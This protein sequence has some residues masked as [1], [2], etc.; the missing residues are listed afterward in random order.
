MASR[1]TLFDSFLQ[2]SNSMFLKAKSVMSLKNSSLKWLCCLFLFFS[3][4][5]SAEDEIYDAFRLIDGAQ[6]AEEMAFWISTSGYDYSDVFRNR[7]RSSN[8]IYLQFGEAFTYPQYRQDIYALED[9]V[10]RQEDNSVFPF[11]LYKEAIKLKQGN[12]RLGFFLV[13]NFL[14]RDW[15]NESMRNSFSR[16]KKLYDITG[17][18]SRFIS[19]L[20]PVVE[21]NS[22]GLPKTDEDGYF[23]YSFANSKRGDNFSAWYHFAG[24]ALNTFIK[25]TK[26][27]RFNPL[28][29]AWET[30]VAIWLEKTMYQRDASQDPI[31]RILIDKEGVRFGNQFANLIK[32]WRRG[33]YEAP[34]QIEPSMRSEASLFPENYALGNGQIPQD[35]KTHRESLESFN[36]SP[37]EAEVGGVIKLLKKYPSRARRIAHFK[38]GEYINRLLNKYKEMLDTNTSTESLDLAFY[39]MVIGF[40]PRHSTWRSRQ[41]NR[42]QR[43]TSLEQKDN[44]TSRRLVRQF[45]LQAQQILVHAI[46]AQQVTL[47]PED[48]DKLKQ[49]LS[50]LGRGGDAELLRLVRMASNGE[51]F[52]SDS[53]AKTCEEITSN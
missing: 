45:S 27:L 14:S 53:T 4:S 44:S 11:D 33:K 50:R 20:T 22:D 24:T 31:K 37:S 52:I 26:Y 5:V 7:W 29:P 46:E 25:S 48:G 6:L 10:D 3:I 17:E 34:S 13:W 32:Q 21:M 8:L 19:N 9:W 40:I 51:V 47:S 35:Y 1:T 49:P 16:T 12:L 42:L 2:S 15:S 41:Q 23:V 36:Q 18:Q 28:P 43:M 39:K 30:Y 38:N